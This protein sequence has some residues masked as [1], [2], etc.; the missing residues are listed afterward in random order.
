MPFLRVFFVVLLFVSTLLFN[1]GLVDVRFD[2]ISYLLGRNARDENSSNAFGIVARYELAKR[3]IVNGESDTSSYA[4][5]AK[6]QSLMSGNDPKETETYQSKFWYPPLRFFLNGLRLTMGKEIINPVEDNRMLKVLEIGYFWERS[7]AWSEAVRSYGQLLDRSDISPDL[8]ATVLMHKAFCHSML[9]DY[10]RARSVY[11]RI[12]NAYPGTEAGTISWKLLDFMD[13]MEKG[14]KE[15]ENG[16]LDNFHKALQYYRTMDYRDAIRCFSQY[17]SSGT[18]DSCAEAKYFKGRS[19]EELGEVDE[20]LSDYRAVMAMPQD[21]A[22]EWGRESNRRMLMLGTFYQQREQIS[23]EAKKMLDKYKDES[24]LT[25]LEKYKG[26]MKQNSLREQLS[27]QADTGTAHSADSVDPKLMNMIS[28]IGDLDLTGEKELKQQQALAQIKNEL[29]AKGITSGAE[30]KEIE[31]RTLVSDNPFR[32]PD[33]IKRVI[34]ANEPQLK[35][36]YNRNLRNGTKFSGRMV[37]E[38]E[39]LP[40]G[41]T[42]QVTL[43]QSDL[44]NHEFE[45]EVTDKIR[46]WQ[47]MP[48]PDSLGSVKIRYPFEFSEEE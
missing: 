37:V 45:T 6:V 42:G 20:A 27:R 10:D 46:N 31:R 22:G 48:V 26:M 24:F 23:D 9:G 43:I 11:E 8:R 15:I 16:Q 36:F 1:A 19:H 28:A 34:D 17:L 21:Q 2:E 12:I 41:K 3:R 44:G 13:E 29:I 18:A 4:L 30:I 14:R 25:G 7:R 35:Y 32:R 47:F 5:E 33:A 40:I 38:I 39:I